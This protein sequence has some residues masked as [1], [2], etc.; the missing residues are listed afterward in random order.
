MKGLIDRINLKLQNI[1]KSLLSNSRHQFV[2]P[3]HKKKNN[4]N[5]KNPHQ[6]LPD[7]RKLHVLS[8]AYGLNLMEE[9]L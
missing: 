6:N 4:K 8:F 3:C 1:L 2:F 5:E 9:D 7:G